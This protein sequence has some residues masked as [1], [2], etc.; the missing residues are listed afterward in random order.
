MDA[1]YKT[2]NVGYRTWDAKYRMIRRM[3][4][5]RGIWNVK[6]KTWNVGCSIRDTG[7]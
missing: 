7:I 1:K 2:Y 5:E 6:Y 4:M 3:W